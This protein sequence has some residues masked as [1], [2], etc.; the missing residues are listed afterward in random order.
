LF[1]PSAVVS[2]QITARILFTGAR[3]G[4]YIWSLFVLALGVFSGPLL[5]SYP[6]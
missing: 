3:L 2:S 6:N 5:I 4:P 1:A